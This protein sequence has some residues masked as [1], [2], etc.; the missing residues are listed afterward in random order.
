MTKKGGLIEKS[1]K[2]YQKQNE[3]PKDITK[4]IEKLRRDKP[5]LIIGGS[6]HL[7]KNVVEHIQD[8][9]PQAE[10]KGKIHLMFQDYTGWDEAKIKQDLFPPS[11]VEFCTDELRDLFPQRHYTTSERL[12]HYLGGGM[13]WLSGANNDNILNRLL[14]T[15]GKYKQGNS[16]GVLV[17]VVDNSD[18]LSRELISQFEPIRLESEKQEETEPVFIYNKQDKCLTFNGK[19]MPLSKKRNQLLKD[20]KKPRGI[21]WVL[22]KYYSEDIDKSVKVIDNKRGAFDKFRSDFNKTWCKTFKLSGKLIKCENKIVSIVQKFK[23]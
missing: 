12:D 8:T 5:I 21:R 9:H 7:V 14:N 17:V 13:L 3:I 15:I 19:K 4:E 18:N 20:L 6:K 10:G 2:G 16:P 22:K 11:F 1:L 23:W